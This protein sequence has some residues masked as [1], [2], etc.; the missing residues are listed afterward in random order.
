M[1]KRGYNLIEVLIAIA[2]VSIITVTFMQALNVG[3]MGTHQVDSGTIALNLARS[4]MEYVKSQD[5]IVYNTSCSATYGIPYMTIE[6]TPS[7]FTVNTTVCKV[8]DVD[9]NILQ[10]IAVTATSQD[11]TASVE[12]EGYKTNSGALPS[13][14]DLP[15]VETT[16]IYVPT[17]PGTDA[18]DASRDGTCNDGS[19]YCFMDIPMYLR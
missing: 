10:H 15:F 6:E 13:L 4:Q 1:K 8:P 5:Y 11:G 3:I 16:D 17:L 18:N 14:R 19:F 9:A 12:L 2:I 7:G